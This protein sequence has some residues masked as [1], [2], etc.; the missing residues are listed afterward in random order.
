[1]TD[2]MVLNLGS[3]D[4]PRGQSNVLALV[5]LPLALWSGQIPL[6]KRYLAILTRNLERENIDLWEPTH[7]FYNAFVRHSEGN[8]QAIEAMQSA[9]KDLVADE[10]LLRTP[11]Y[12][13]VLAEALLDVGR[14][15][16]AS[17]MLKAA[18]NLQVRTQ[19]V[20]CLPEL[21]R[22]KARILRHLGQDGAAHDIIAEARERAELAGARSFEM[23]ILEE[24]VRMAFADSDLK[25]TFALHC[26]LKELEDKD[27]FPRRRVA[28]RPEQLGRIVAPT[29]P[30]IWAAG[31]L[32]GSG[33]LMPPTNS[34]E[35]F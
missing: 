22:I 25:A 13:G 7:R 4:Q 8:S 24:M 31:I 9:I 11:M 21:L 17:R 16:E 14:A 32:S 28:E 6:L 35:P 34:I 2:E 27:D 26:S 10:S 12:Q 15:G 19:E 1:M 23:R 20:W 33:R 30:N 5:A 18:E 3:A 29:P